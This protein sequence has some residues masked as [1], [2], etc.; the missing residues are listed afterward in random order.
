MTEIEQIWKD[1]AIERM[2]ENERV[3]SALR[4]R[5]SV[6]EFHL[7]KCIDSAWQVYRATVGVLPVEL[8]SDKPKKA[9][10]K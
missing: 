4:E 7:G 9:K 5:V 6:L 1:E 3:I 2:A 8:V 10:K